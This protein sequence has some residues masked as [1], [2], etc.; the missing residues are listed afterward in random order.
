MS[1]KLEKRIL[2]FAFTVNFLFF[3]VEIV[4]GVLSHSMGL[5]ADSLDMLADAFVYGI[6]LLAVG[7]VRARKKRIARLSG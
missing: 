1:D 3:T 2:V 4:A 5:V 6:S 7:A